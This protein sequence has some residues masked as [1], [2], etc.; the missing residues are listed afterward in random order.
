MFYGKIENYNEVELNIRGLFIK[1][2]ENNK[3][4]FELEIESQ[5]YDQ[6]ETAVKLLTGLIGELYLYYLNIDNMTKTDA[7][8][9]LKKLVNESL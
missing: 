1:C 5:G 9:R 3:V 4:T 8:E 2:K 6:E 7:N